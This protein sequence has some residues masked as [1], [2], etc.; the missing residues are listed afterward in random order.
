MAN[1][2]TLLKDLINLTSKQKGN[3]AAIPKSPFQAPIKGN[4]QNSGNFSPNAPT[5]ARHKVHQGVDLRASGGTPIYPI[6][7]GT[8]IAV[9]SSGK[10]GHNITIQHINNVKAY[11]AHLGSIKVQK[12]DKVNL[13]TVIGTVGDSGNAKGTFPHLHI[14]VWQNGSLIDPGTLFRVPKYSNVSK[15]EKPWLSEQAKQEARNFNLN[16]HLQPSRIAHHDLVE[17]IY[18]IASDYLEVVED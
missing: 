6:A 13:N 5:D 8:V 9:G 10:G 7:N 12:G 14:Q 1:I 18:K 2:D 15:N 4:Y 11:Y 16:K 3:I 17:E